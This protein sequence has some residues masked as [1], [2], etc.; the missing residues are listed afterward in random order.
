MVRLKV[1]SIIYLELHNKITNS[2]PKCKSEGIWNT[3]E[4]A[5]KSGLKGANGCKI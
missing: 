2:S 1:Q 3:L 4:N 5:R